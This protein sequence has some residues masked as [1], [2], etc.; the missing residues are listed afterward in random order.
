MV[1]AVWARVEMKEGLN[2]LLL[3]EEERAHEE[4]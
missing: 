4:D 3:I 2:F 1:P